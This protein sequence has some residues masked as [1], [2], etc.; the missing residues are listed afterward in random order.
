MIPSEPRLDI[1]FIVLLIT[2]IIMIFNWGYYYRKSRILQK[3][4]DSQIESN[5]FH[6]LN[7]KTN[8]IGGDAIAKRES[9][10]EES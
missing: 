4:L 1:P 5:N 3:K 8:S 7:N 2:N 9:K 6:P 10:G